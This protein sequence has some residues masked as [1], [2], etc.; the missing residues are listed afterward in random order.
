MEPIAIIGIGCRFP[1][2]KSPE[3]FW[4]LL[5]NGIDAISEVPSDRW[6]IDDYYSPD[7]NEPGKM[8]T[9]YG[10]FLEQVDQFDPSFFSISPR[11][12]ERIDPHQRLVLE[13]SW[14]A[15][16]NA[17]IVPATLAGTQTGVFVG[18]GNYDYGLLLSKDLNQVTAYD[19]TGSTLGVSA[20]R[21]SYSLDLRGPSLTV[22]T[23]CSSSL[24][25]LHLACQSLRNQETDTC[26]VGAVSL[27][28]SPAQ[29]ITYSKARMMASDG[30]CKTF[31]ASADG[32]VR[33]E[34]CG[35]VVIKRLQQAMADGDRIQAIIRGSA[36]NQDGLSNGLTAPNGPSQQAVI[37][38]ALAAA[39]VNPQDI[40]YVE[41]HGT[42]TSLGDPIEFKALKSVLMTDR[43]AAHPCWLGSVKTNIGHL[44]A[45]A[46]M[47]GL[48]KVILSL[49]HKV[50]PPNLHL[51]QINPYITLG[52]TTFEM[53]SQPQ[54][55]TTVSGS[56]YA[57]IS[58]FGFGG[59]NAHFI[60]EEAPSSETTREQTALFPSYLLPLSAKSQS[61][62]QTLA[63]QYADYLTTHPEVA[64]QDLCG[65]ASTRRSCF[66]Y[67]LMVVA[68]TREQ[69]Q[70]QLLNFAEST[71]A[72]EGVVAGQIVKPKHRK[73][74]FLFTG[75][76]S[77]YVGMGRHLYKTEPVFRAT[78][79][80]CADILSPCLDQPLLALLYPDA[81]SLEPDQASCL[82]DT[83]YT[84]PALFAVE[85]ALYKLWQSWGIHPDVVMGHSVGEY[86]AA[87]IAGVFSL[88][89][90]LRLIAT[91]GHLMQALPA[92][93]GMLAVMASEADINHW[94][95][96]C[97]YPVA[98][99]A[100][101][102][103]K[104]TVLSGSLQGLQA[105][106]LQLQQAG[107]KTKPLVV[108]HGFHSPLMGPMLSSFREVAT[109]IRYSPPKLKVISNLSG[110]IAADE[111]AT[112]DYW[113]QHIL[114]PVRYADSIKTLQQQGHT[115]LIEMGPKPVL[116]GMARHCLNDPEGVL[117]LPSLRPHQ[118]DCQQILQ[119]LG[120]LYVRGVKIDWQNRYQ[121]HPY[122]Q[123]TLP[124]YPF[125]RQRYWPET[126]SNHPSN[127]GHA[128]VTNSAEQWTPLLELLH[129]GKTDELLQSLET[130]QDTSLSAQGRRL[131]PEV[132]QFL[133]QQ[134]H[135]QL[136]QET[137]T[138]WLY[139]PEW[140]LKPRSPLNTPEQSLS[141][142]GS[143]LIFCDRCG[144][145]TALAEKLHAQGH[146]CLLVFTHSET[147]WLDE[148]GW[149]LHPTSL[150]DYRR[151]L[152]HDWF[153]DHPPLRGILHLWALDTEP[154]E[155]LTQESLRQ[156][157]TV[158]SI[159]V[160]RLVQALEGYATDQTLRLWLI[161]QGV[162]PV[163]TAPTGVAQAPLWG[164]SKVIA[165]EYPD[166]WGGIIDLNPLSFAAQTDDL[167]TEIM[168]SQG[169]E[170]IALREQRYVTR[171]VRH[172]PMPSSTR[173]SID[174]EASYII[175]GGV[176]ALGLRIA[177]WLVSGGAQHLILTS[178]RELS[179]D[180][181]QHI[182]ALTASG[183]TIACL[184]AD[185][186]CEAD[187]RQLINSP[188]LKK[189]PLKGI[190]HAAGLT[191]YQTIPEISQSQFE[192]VIAAKV[193][194]TWLLHQLTQKYDLDFFVGFS[195]IASIWG[196]R[197]Q[198]HYA[199][200]NYF[201]DAITHYR[202]SQ[203]LSAVSINWGPWAEGGMA[204][205]EAQALLSRVGIETLQPD[206]A[207]TALEHVLETGRDQQ[208][209]AN[210]DWVRFKGIYEARKAKA[211]LS[212][213][214]SD[215][216]EGE[217]TDPAI[218]TQSS[219]ILR[220]LESSQNQQ[221]RVSVLTIFLQHELGKILKLDQNQL[222]E[223]H[224]NLFEVGLDS[225]LAFELVSLIRTQLSV[226]LPV[227][228]FLQEPTIAKITNLLLIELYSDE[229]FD[230]ASIPVPSLLDFEAEAQLDDDLF[231][232]KTSQD[233]Y[234]PTNILLTGPTGFLG[235]FLLEALLHQT[236]ADIYC[237]VRATDPASGKQRIKDNLEHYKLW[238]NKYSSR[239]HPIIG[240]LS[241]PKLGLSEEL[242]NHLSRQIDV[243][244]HN[245]AILNFVYPYAGL[246][247]TNVV[248][249]REVIRLASY[250]KAKPLHYISTDAVFDS[251]AYYGK[252]VL[253]SEPIHYTEGLENGYT[254]SKWV[255][256]KLVM[257]AQK[258]GLPA[259]IYRPPL[260]SGDS[261]T[262]IWNTNDFTC[263]FLKGCIQMGSMPKILNWNSGTTFIPVDYISQAVVYLSQ[264]K[265]FLGKA[266]NLSNPGFTSWGEVGNWIS[267]YGY[268]I[269]QVAYEAW[270]KSLMQYTRSGQ[271][272][273]LSGLLPFLLKRWSPAKLTLTELFQN[274]PR[275]D[276]QQVLSGLRES[277]ISCPSIDSKLLRNYFSYFNKS[278]FIKQAQP[279]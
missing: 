61:A 98:I 238:Q 160:L 124:T 89:D 157:Q 86:V 17:G 147:G 241:L 259:T 268:P 167:L 196:S 18:C 116:L 8:S 72:A 138:K 245:G 221:G 267:S 53:P 243:I 54:S 151:L 123:V 249:T 109:S 161:T 188:Y 166:L 150:D 5:Y 235:A 63:Q 204:S 26:L 36:L 44:E 23:A 240:D 41:A 275:L 90:G 164:L 77:Q 279:L 172:Q 130:A 253:E 180:T 178:R 19:G 2:A 111:M 16:E 197:G 264:Q 47:A 33:G 274:R 194:G 65:T 91:R 265:Q 9:R 210:V 113:C 40:S 277:G 232:V 231:P 107:I 38:Q 202:R 153:K 73:V 39:Q 199:A 60:L 263:R 250:G 22:E 125:Q 182:K 242:F 25:A 220:Q 32:Y 114:Q 35:F 43:T 135:K 139:S 142:L 93:G 106:D 251:T 122:N 189:Y 222:P 85:Y 100:L 203:G 227:S 248:G 170:E 84:Q 83:A 15:L 239:I 272:N 233:S 80:H 67:R 225:L 1:K 132:I 149:Q 59:T 254:Q 236:A 97:E 195:S 128:P 6:N 174:P 50:I 191:A 262:G 104:N 14:E 99:A 214:D 58:S 78:L 81:N 213:I 181:Q 217:S 177:H 110:A 244:Y 120:T 218:Q 237:L 129:Q 68:D 92:G 271:D 278:G 131:L 200:A 28:L 112:P 247:P 207:I 74:A 175:T 42:G 87:C 52:G 173:L 208:V 62:L 215:I 10:G 156:A 148:P 12:A 88:E 117:L 261:R 169:E 209:V 276:C 82:D 229:P 11:E 4:Q 13:V 103:P 27:M 30:R 48:L 155:T 257:I 162:A 76:G 230:D 270:E 46:G 45:S 94:L 252:T 7:P 136:Q 108:S 269:E 256:E 206:A 29:T 37:R 24:V 102:G 55:W 105:M 96:K 152:S 34:G 228:E 75:Q 226:E 168:N 246:K 211:L 51:Q 154:A 146:H 134:H 192:T 193:E 57:G 140:R 187:I 176:G 165:L 49:K 56:R 190:V 184:K 219:S 71:T 64:L 141:Q 255:A 258:R 95:E 183:A 212:E 144:L 133:T 137:F 119:S 126:V 179:E 266:F 31:D 234:C 127:N 69:L 216:N 3:A 198:A 158:G 118:P 205:A 163:E 121:L 260:I 186:T 201:I 70:Q 115:V 143:W 159:S 66:D 21:L 145:G 185:V 224:Q 171:L 101:N 79:D 223:P 20:N 273:P